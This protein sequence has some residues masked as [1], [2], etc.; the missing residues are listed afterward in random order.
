M[1]ATQLFHRGDHRQPKQAVQPGDL[2]IA[3]PEGQRFEIA[4]DGPEAADLAAGGWP[5]RST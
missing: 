5:S 3:A 4:A 2:T 1:P